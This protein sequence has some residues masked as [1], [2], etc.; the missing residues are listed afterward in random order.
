MR[1]KGYHEAKRVDSRSV[2]AVMIVSSGAAA[3]RA[4]RHRSSLHMTRD[5][6]FP[7]ALITERNKLRILAE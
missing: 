3:S 7:P 1:W 2:C 4:T 5:F 6:E